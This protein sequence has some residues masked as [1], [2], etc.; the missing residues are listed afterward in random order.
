MKRVVITVTVDKGQATCQPVRVNVEPG[1]T[2]RWTSED[3]HLAVDFGTDTPFTT[4]QIWAASR[5]Q[6]TP[7]AVVKSDVES[8]TVFRPTMSINGSVVAESLG[9]IVFP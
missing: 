7:V 1:D 2:V 4:N 6:M 8:G 9:D 5:D 3:G